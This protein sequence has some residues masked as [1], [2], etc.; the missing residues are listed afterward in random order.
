MQ[1]NLT[2]LSN[3]SH[4]LLIIGGGAF[5]AAAA[6]DAAMRG[7]KVALVER[8]D[9]GGG[10][11]AE[12]FKMVHGGIR[13]IQHFDVPRVRASARERSAMLR[14]APHLVTPLPI[15]IPTYGYGR[16]GKFFLGTGMYLYDLMTLDRN[17]GIP[18]R[19]R[20]VPLTRF[21]NKS[22]LLAH[23][24][25]VDANGLTGAAIF[26]DGQMYSPTRLVLAFVKTAAELGATVCNY[27]EAVDFLWAG[28]R[29]CGA[30][31]KDRLSGSEFDVRARLV[32]NAA[33]PS[34]EYLLEGRPKFNAWQRGHF[35]RDAYFVVNRRPRSG[36]AL[37]VQGQTRDRDALVSRAARHLF[38]VPWRQHTLIGVWHRLFPRHPDEAMVE[39]QE[40]ETWLKEIN[41]SYP[42]LQLSRD[43]VIF[44]NC[45]LV[46]FGDGNTAPDELSFG[47]E[48]RFVDHRRSHGV[49]GLVTLI[50]IRYTTARG[51]AS[52][53]LDMLL[54]Q[55]PNAPKDH[56]TEHVALAGGNIENF[57]A[58][59]AAA[60]RNCPAQVGKPVLH[61]LLRN[62]GTEYRC[63]LESG[64][65]SPAELQQIGASG[66]LQ[67]EVS[68][69]VE[70]EM[71]VR[72]DDVIF[73]RTGLGTGDHPGAA[74][75]EAVA[76]HMQKL[77]QWSEAR[78]AEEVDATMTTLSR[79]HAR[80]LT[81]KA[82]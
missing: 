25:D 72:L 44:A 13:Y 27:A 41:D 23:F 24:P 12:C 6:R 61:T 43:D 32:L 76:Q 48:S 49:E 21:M 78:R 30:R 58:F 2:A 17:S 39:E 40:L 66:T 81:V 18:D 64:H 4:D 1:R 77:L 22:E 69:A 54:S 74:T 33:G 63:V 7:L 73:R 5:G 14:I 3:E 45:G 11:S 52:R 79:H 36:Y 16:K 37:A 38:V 50:G 56:G 71:A 80:P 65:R 53:A 82:V 8:N 51:D 9:F 47:K 26:D 10:A 34:A 62:Y 20:H 35:S 68:Y 55:L 42:T 59:T 67:A 15:V 57:A 75:V 31:V 28:Q 70:H 19:T 60:E 46:P 29:V